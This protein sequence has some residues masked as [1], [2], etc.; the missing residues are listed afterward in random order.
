[1]V[2]YLETNNEENLN[3]YHKLIKENQQFLMSKSKETSTI[4]INETGSF[5]FYNRGDQKTKIL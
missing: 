3:N 5:I 1:M 2:M 4:N